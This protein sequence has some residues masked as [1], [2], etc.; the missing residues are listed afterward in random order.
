[1]HILLLSY[2]DNHALSDTEAFVF[3]LGEVHSL[4]AV[5]AVLGLLLL[6]V[7]LLLDGLLFSYTTTEAQL[8]ADLKLECSCLWLQGS[9]RRRSKACWFF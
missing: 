4:L 1:M 3:G 6:G 8:W 2:L 5:W 9:S 7:F